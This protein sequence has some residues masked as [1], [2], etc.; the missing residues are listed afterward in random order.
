MVAITL[1]QES[2]PESPF[3]LYAHEDVLTRS[4]SVL[5]AMLKPTTTTTPAGQ[6]HH[7][8]QREITLEKAD[9]KSTNLY[10]NWLYTGNIH[11]G[12]RKDEFPTTLTSTTTTTTTKPTSKATETQPALS[13]LT[14]SYLLGTR[15]NDP[16]FLDALLDA[17]VTLVTT[18]SASQTKIQLN[19]LMQRVKHHYTQLPLGCKARKLFVHLFAH[20]G[21]WRLLEKSDD[22]DFLLETK[23]VIM[24]GAADDPTVRA[25]RCGFHEHGVDGGCYREGRGG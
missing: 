23:E 18:T 22:K 20:F 16:S 8:H 19:L 17:I 13:L 5:Q 7:H 24:R 6:Q 11:A 4:S 10:I 9:A 25:G 15:L 21:D 12:H 2:T 1:Q 14:T 3:I